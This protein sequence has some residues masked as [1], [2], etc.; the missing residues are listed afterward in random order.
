MVKPVIKQQNAAKRKKYDPQ[1]KQKVVDRIR[2]IA[3]TYPQCGHRKMHVYLNREGII[4]GR[5]KTRAIMTELGLML[6]NKGKSDHGNGSGPPFP[7]LI[8]GIEASG[9]DEIWV[10]DTTY[11]RTVRDGFAYLAVVMDLFTRKIIGYA[12]SR[13]ND[14]DL[15]LK[16][17]RMAISARNRRPRYHHSDQGSQYTSNIYI[18]ELKRYGIQISMSKRAYPYDNSVMERFFNTLKSEE[19]DMWEYQTFDDARLRIQYFIE[20]VYNNAR[21]HA[22]LGYVTPNEYELLNP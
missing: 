3:E 4:I 19:V 9:P 10:A 11:I 16:A 5:H 6:E 21:V 20:E 8:K 14:T 7:N 2:L 1:D 22:A 12:I 17:L 18:E 13:Y 15:V